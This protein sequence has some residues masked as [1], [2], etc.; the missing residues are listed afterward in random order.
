MDVY[1]KNARGRI[2][3]VVGWVEQTYRNPAIPGTQISPYPP[4]MYAL[5]TTLV[6]AKNGNVLGSGLATLEEII[7]SASEAEYVN[8]PYTGIAIYSSSNNTIASGTLVIVAPIS[9]LWNIV[10][11]PC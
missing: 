8:T 2:D 11:V 1:S 5:T 3:R 4:L 10:A 7:F 9:G 6:T